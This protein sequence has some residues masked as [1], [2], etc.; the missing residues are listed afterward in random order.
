M[1]KLTDSEKEALETV[2]K[3]HLAADSTTSYIDIEVGFD[4]GLD[5]AAAQITALTAERDAL[6]L[7]IKARDKLLMKIGIDPAGIKVDD[8]G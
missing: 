1:R 4:A 2:W 8:N 3:K 5:Y 6:K 7:Q